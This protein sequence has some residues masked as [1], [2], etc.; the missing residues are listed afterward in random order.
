MEGDQK[1]QVRSVQR[2][3]ESSRVEEELWAQAYQ[4]LWPLIR[5]RV[6]DRGGH[7]TRRATPPIAR[8]KGA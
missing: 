2:C 8:A 6:S 1:N 4:R 7:A 5:L 3:C